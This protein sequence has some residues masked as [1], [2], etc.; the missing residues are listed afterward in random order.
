MAKEVDAVVSIAVVLVVC[1]GSDGRDMFEE[2]SHLDTVFLWKCFVKR[3][4]LYLG[5]SKA[6]SEAKNC[7]GF[8]FRLC[9]CVDF[10][11][12]VLLSSTKTK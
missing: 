7:D 2:I 5:N 9:Y 1:Q 11:S 8:L 3:T 12:L 10:F 4:G 6:T